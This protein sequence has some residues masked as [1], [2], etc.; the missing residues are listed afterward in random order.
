MCIGYMSTLVRIYT[1][2]II[3]NRCDCM[4]SHKVG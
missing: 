4:R 2:Y 3:Y 1:I